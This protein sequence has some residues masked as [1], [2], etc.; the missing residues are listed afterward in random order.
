MIVTY[1]GD[2]E[3]TSFFMTQ[4]EE[5]LQADGYQV[6]PLFYNEDIEKWLAG[7]EELLRGAFFLT[8]N[9]AGIYS[10]DS[11]LIEIAGEKDVIKETVKEDSP[12]TDKKEE[13]KI[14]RKVMLV[15]RF[16]MRCINI[17]VDHPYHYHDFLY[18][19]I[20]F[21]RTRY[22]QFC[23][24]KQ[25]IAYMKRYFPEIAL[26]GFLPSGGTGF[27]DGV[28]A[29]TSELHDS[30]AQSGKETVESTEDKMG[31]MQVRSWNERPIDS[32]FLYNR[33]C[34]MKELTTLRE[35]TDNAS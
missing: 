17:I 18:E 19:Q 22:L 15:D 2:V 11:C 23:I 21:R 34:H 25:H 35:G 8:F 7:K 1:H 14:P 10:K 33:Q 27:A 13:E 4:I 28:T 20:R 32:P 26:G 9:F 30:D 16:M 3:T 6:C 5:G 31:D 29:K 24:D 12:E